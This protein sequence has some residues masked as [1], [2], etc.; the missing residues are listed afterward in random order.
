MRMCQIRTKKDWWVSIWFL[1]KPNVQ[2]TLKTSLLPEWVAVQKKK[3]KRKVR[4]LHPITTKNHVFPQRNAKV[5]G[6]RE[7]QTKRQRRSASETSAGPRPGPRLGGQQQPVPR[8]RQRRVQRPGLATLTA[9]LGFFWV[10]DIGVTHVLFQV[11]Y[12]LGM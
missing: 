2:G 4:T 5:H 7:R 11:A 1:F 8:P 6:P 3:K 10:G 9:S 12:F